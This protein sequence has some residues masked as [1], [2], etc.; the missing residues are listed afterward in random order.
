MNQLKTEYKR[1]LKSN[2]MLISFDNESEEKPDTQKYEYKMLE[3]NYIA[4]LMKF[5]LSKEGESTVL[6][7]DITSKKSLSR[8]LEYR[9]IGLEDIKK[10]VFGLIRTI[11][12]MERFLLGSCGLVL[13][14]DY[15]YAEPESLEPVFCYLPGMENA[16]DK[17][18][19]DLF[20]Q[21]LSKL[22]Q[23][24]HD[25]VVLAYSLYQESLKD[26]CVLDDLLNIM[27]RH[28]KNTK[29]ETL[30]PEADA[31][32]GKEEAYED[33]KIN[34]VESKKTDKAQGF[35]I[36]SLFGLKKEKAEKN[37]GIKEEK[38]SSKSIKKEER[39]FEE[40]S[41]EWT[42]LFKEESMERNES[43]EDEASNHTVLLSEQLNNEAGYILKS[44]DKSIEDI[45]LT[46]FP[47]IIG[48]Q[49]RICDYIIKNDMVSRL[50]LR[51][52]KDRGENFS[53]RDLNSL[54]GTRLDGRLLGN[55]EIAG[56]CV[57]NEVGIANLRYVFVKV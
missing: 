12:N 18:L 23:N 3:N 14:I 43:Y 38:K 53:I 9:Q 37:K 13:D 40:E 17:S 10:L 21:I 50:H 41:D 48:K 25:G 24:D 22:D 20:S 46:Y 45:K 32:L 35:S 36:K 5:K 30:L 39:E 6:Y 7:Y 55:E 34:L 1:D 26:N 8:I 44:T 15:I 51:I 52:D 33:D 56:L 16:I 57:G 54:N 4:G 47:F 11:S 28:N 2:Y 27:S 49:E 42:E 31:V 19:S 29:K